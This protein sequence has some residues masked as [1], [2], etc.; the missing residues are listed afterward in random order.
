MDD[1]LRDANVLVTGATGFLGSH[2]VR[3]LLAAGAT[4]HMIA[5]A[6]S[7]FD[8]LSDVLP[9]I[10]PWTADIRDA[11]AVERCVTSVRPDLV[12]HLAAETA[13]RGWILS[14]ELGTELLQRSYDINFVGTVNV[15]RAVARAAPAARVIRAGG[16]EEYGTGPL[17]YHEHQREAPIS[18]YS[19]SQ[20]AATHLA[21]MFHRQTGLAIVTLRLA[22]LYGPRQAAGF[23]IPSLILACLAGRSFEMTAGDQTRDFVYVDDAVDAFVRVAAAPASIG[24]VINIGSGVEWRIRRVADLIV[25]LSGSKSRLRIGARPDQ[26][27]GLSRLVC[28]TSRAWE[29]LSWKAQTSLEAGLERC[30]AWYRTRPEQA[31]FFS[32]QT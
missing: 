26:T 8:R 18:P 31:A 16:L 20:V 32:G 14:A 25:Q 1:S 2:V 19:A 17:P 30:I 27:I 13:G 21:E 4:V 10:R 9:D 5:R 15:L 6:T 22:L 28:D 29:L 12:F 11:T 23:F 3:R 7:A 24:G